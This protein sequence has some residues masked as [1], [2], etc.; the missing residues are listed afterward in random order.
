M[1]WSPFVALPDT[2]SLTNFRKFTAKTGP[3]FRGYFWTQSRIKRRRLRKCNFSSR[4]SSRQTSFF[5]VRSL[6]AA[7]VSLG[8]FGF[9]EGD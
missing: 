3:I 6:L 9:A 2:L 4:A 7:A 5:S 1:V 8:Y